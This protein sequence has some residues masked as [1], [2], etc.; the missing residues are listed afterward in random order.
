MADAQ[1]ERAGIQISISVLHPLGLS[2]WSFLLLVF[3]PLFYL[4][5]LPY[6]LTFLL[7]YILTSFFLISKYQIKISNQNIK[8]RR[9]PPAPQRPTPIPTNP[10]LHPQTHPPYP[11]NPQAHSATPSATRLAGGG[12]SAKDKTR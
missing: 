4:L 12:R 8:R 9:P 7:P 11:Q 3:P 1:D 10:S 6:F 2:S 5:L